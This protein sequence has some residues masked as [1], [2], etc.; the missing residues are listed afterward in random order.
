METEGTHAPTKTYKKSTYT[1]QG[2]IKA[3]C[4]CGEE[5]L[6]DQFMI[7]KVVCGKLWSRKAVP[8]A[9]E[10]LNYLPFTNGML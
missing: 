10:L 1:W 2:S 5:E 6:K 7:A 9:I 8:L 3:A 4:A